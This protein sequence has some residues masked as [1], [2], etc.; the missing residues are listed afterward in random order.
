MPVTSNSNCLREKRNCVYPGRNNLGDGI[1]VECIC[2]KCGVTH[3]L[4]ILW[5][6]RGKPKKYCPPCKT[7]V[8]TIEPI[9][10]CGVHSDIRRGVDKAP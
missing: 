3:R 1:T 7:F 5:S 6:G 9:D 10:Y 8:S 4:K 2:P